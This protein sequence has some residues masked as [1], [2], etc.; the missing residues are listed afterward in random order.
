[1]NPTQDSFPRENNSRNLLIMIGI[2]ILIIGIVFTIV[3]I[4]KPKTKDFITAKDEIKN[5]PKEHIEAIEPSIHKIYN[6]TNEIRLIDDL[7]DELVYTESP[8][9][10]GSVNLSVNIRTSLPYMLK[11]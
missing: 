9:P 8:E 6:L 11:I 5:T 2:L 4:F 7:F 1:M 10:D 3:F